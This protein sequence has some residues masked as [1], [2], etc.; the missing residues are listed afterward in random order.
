MLLKLIDTSSFY[1]PDEAQVTILNHKDLAGSLIKQAT[2]SRVQDFAS[3]LTPIQGKTYLHILAMGAGEFY[4][5]NRN[6]DYFPESN[7]ID[8]HN[9]FETAPAHIFRNHVNKNPAI[10]IGQ[11]V[12]S[13][14]NDRMHRVELIAELWNDKAPDIVDKIE[15]GDWP[16]TSMA[17]RTPFDVCSICGNKARIREEYCEHLS[18]HLGK[19]Y[20]D[21]RKVMALNLAPLRFFDISIVFRPADVTSAVLQKVASESQVIGSVD[22]AL[23]AGL[24]D[25]PMQKTATLKK[26]SEL[27][28]EVDGDVVSIDSSLDNLVSRVSDPKESS[29]DILRNYKLNEV[30]S[31]LGHLGISPSVGFLAELIARK[32]LGEEGKGLGPMAAAYID[33]SG[34][35]DM[36]NFDRDFGEVT[37]PNMGIMHALIPSLHDSSYLPEYVEDRIHHN[38]E[39]SMYGFVQGTNRGF[40]GNGPIIEPTVYEKFREQNLKADE[41]NKSALINVFNTIV[42]IGGAALAAKWYITQV[43]ERKMKQQEQNKASDDVKIVLVKSASDYKLTY[44]LAKTAMLKLIQKKKID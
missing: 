36:L 20:P 16:K 38:K 42:A 28:K 11:V 40:T 23:M 26:L 13:V 10:A 7:L 5:A 6:A 33:K 22:E 21:G 32:I 2:D 27:T 35:A 37:E 43:I 30:F 19:V 18:D 8:Y 12:F 44:K 41:G 24:Q 4:G 15:S 31:T 1:S 34:T 9:T 14:Y 25:L 39:A 29:I 17:C 3:K